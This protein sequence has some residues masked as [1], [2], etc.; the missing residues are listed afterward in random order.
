MILVESIN[1]STLEKILG[2]KKDDEKSISLL[3]RFLEKEHID[4]EGTIEF[5]SNLN[6]LRNMKLHRN[7]DSKPKKEQKKAITYFS[8]E[9]S[10]SADVMMSILSYARIL[11]SVLM[12]VAHQVAPE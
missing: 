9:T 5:L 12:K 6:T 4:D 10:S 7:S 2:G 11:L 3:K 1:V 8:L